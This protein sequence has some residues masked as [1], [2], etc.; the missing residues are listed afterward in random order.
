MAVSHPDTDIHAPK[1]DSFI[2]NFTVVLLLLI[3]FGF[4]IFYAAGIATRALMGDQTDPDVV[5]QVSERLA[6]VG[7]VRVGTGGTAGGTASAAAGPVDGG[8]VYNPACMACHATGAAGAP[9]YGNQEDWAPR[10]A[11]GIDTLYKHSIEGFNA[12]APKG[13]FSN[14][15][16]EQVKAAVDH[17]VKS[18]E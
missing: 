6:P 11:K 17:M 10:I 5:A 3:A 8:Q 15:S 13:G 18:V 4:A 16:D 2:N 1:P 14:L 7:Q 12:M 9:K